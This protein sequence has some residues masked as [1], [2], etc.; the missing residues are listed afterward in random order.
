MYKSLIVV[1]ALAVSS[2]VLAKSDRLSDARYLQAA[3]CQALFSSRSLGKT[4][5]HLIDALIKRES[6]AREPLVDNRADELRT[7]VARRARSGSQAQK[8]ELLAER[9]GVC[10]TFNAPAGQSM[11][12]VS[13]PATTN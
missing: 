9:D 10:M 12:A 3:R 4:D 13:K 7:D 5:S 2:P 11:T 1:A 8:A 6:V